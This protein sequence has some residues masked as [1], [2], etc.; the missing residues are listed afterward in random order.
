MF[1]VFAD[2]FRL[3]ICN[4]TRQTN[5]WQSKSSPRTLYIPNILFVSQ[6]RLFRSRV[7]SNARQPDKWCDIYRCWETGQADRVM[8]LVLVPG[9]EDYTCRLIRAI[10]SREFRPSLEG[11]NLRRNQPAPRKA[12]RWSVR[13]GSVTRGYFLNMVKMHSPS[14]LNPLRRADLRVPQMRKY[15][16]PDPGMRCS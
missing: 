1:L 8:M 15:F 14:K 3:I 6:D 10:R 4:L 9:W 5:R 2:F 13:R 7:K 16:L 11:S 12:G